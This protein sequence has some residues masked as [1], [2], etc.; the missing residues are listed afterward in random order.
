MYKILCL[1]TG[2]EICWPKCYPTPTKKLVP[3]E[4][5]E[6]IAH[7]HDTVR[8]GGIICFLTEDS[9]NWFINRRLSY[10]PARTDNQKLTFMNNLFEASG[11]DKGM[12][13]KKHM[14]E[15]IDC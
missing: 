2:S 15:L 10:N 6:N 12:Y 11:M 9:A 4:I 14:F 13:S 8:S 3:S 5:I 7:F 1:T